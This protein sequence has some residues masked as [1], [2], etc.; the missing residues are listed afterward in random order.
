MHDFSTC[1]KALLRLKLSDIYASYINMR[2]LKSD[3][4][5]TISYKKAAGKSIGIEFRRVTLFIPR[6]AVT[7]SRATMLI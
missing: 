4:V 3:S 6:I 1:S 5:Q 2:Q 7:L